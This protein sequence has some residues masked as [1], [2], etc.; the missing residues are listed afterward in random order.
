MLIL[1][2]NLLIVLF[3]QPY[4][5]LLPG[6]AK[7]VLD[8]DGFG[9]GVLMSITGV[10]ALLGSLVIASM[11]ATNRGMIL[12]LSSLVMGV[13][14]IAFSASTI[15]W[16]T[17]PIMIVV[18]IGQ[19]GRMSLGNVLLQSYTEPD[20]RARVMSI[21]MLEFSVTAFMVFVV[22]IVAN[23]MG[24]Q[25][26][27]GACSAILVAITLGALVFSPRTRNLQ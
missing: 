24:I 14:L 17:L 5:M 25:M 27:L 13:A 21:Y 12:L 18:G 7:D 6:F 1:T 22:G 23:F 8:A 3:S 4:Q 10:G 19:A 26:A 11:P 16:V 20:Y 9:L 15:Y 2:I